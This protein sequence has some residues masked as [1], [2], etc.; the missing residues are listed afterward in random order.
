[1]EFITLTRS[2]AGRR[3][4]VT[5]TPPRRLS[6]ARPTDPS[7]IGPLIFLFSRREHFARS[8]L[9]RALPLAL[10]S[11]SVWPSN[12]YPQPLAPAPTTTTMDHLTSS[13]HRFNSHS[14]QQSCHQPRQFR[15]ESLTCFTA[16]RYQMET[17]RW[18]ISERNKKLFRLRSPLWYVQCWIHQ[19]FNLQHILYR[20]N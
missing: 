10:P 3:P 5:P 12:Y 19:G 15:S 4:C 8:S 6:A 13:H 18:S 9:A 7:L 17:I 11:A 1:M 14:S 16:S 20:K 2:R